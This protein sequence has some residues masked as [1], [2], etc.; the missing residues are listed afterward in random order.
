MKRLENQKKK[1]DQAEGKSRDYSELMHPKKAAEVKGEIPY[2]KIEDLMK[3]E[4]VQGKPIEE[5]KQIWLAYHVQKDVIAAAI[6][7]ATFETL[8]QNAKKHPVFIFPIPRSQGFEFIV[9]Q[10]AANTVHFTPL[11]CY[12]VRSCKSLVQYTIEIKF[13]TGSQRECT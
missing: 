9:L 5:I 2:K 11:L 4:L 6:P 10:F 1:A 7:T 12:Q 8:M 13:Y 3:I